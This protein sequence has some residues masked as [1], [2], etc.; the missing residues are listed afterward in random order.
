MN[1]LLM[2]GLLAG[3]CAMPGRADEAASASYGGGVR[4]VDL[5][6]KGSRGQFQ[7]YNGKL[8]S[9]AEGDVWVSNQGAK[10]LIDLDFNDIG[11]TEENGSLHVDLGDWFKGSAKI[12][13][14]THRQNMTDFGIIV[15]GTFVKIPMNLSRQKFPHDLN[16]LYKRTESEVNVALLD[17]HNSARWLSL[18]YWNVYKKGT[19]PSGYYTGGIL[20]FD[21]AN[22][23]NETN[24]VAL[25][26]GREITGS[27]AMALDLIRREFKDMAFVKKYGGVNTA[28]RPALPH[29]QV[30]AAEM[31]LRYNPSKDLAFTGALSGRQRENLF[32]LYK[33]NAAVAAFNAA[34]KASDKLSLTARLYGRMVEID[35]NK[36]YIN[37]VTNNPPANTHEFDKL[38]AR[39][40]FALSYRPI[41]PVLIKAGYKV[42]LTHRRDA[43]TEIFRAA[44]Y[45]D[46]TYVVNTQNA[47]SVA[48][49]DV[50]HIFSAGMKTELPCDISV[51]ADYKRM[52]ANR[53]A[54]VNMPTQGDEA[55][56][57][58]N[59]PLPGHIEFY[60]LAQY[61]NERN[62][63]EL[64][65][66]RLTRNAYRTGLDWDAQ[67]KVFVGADASYETSRRTTNGWFG[68]ANALTNPSLTGFEHVAGMY[69]RQNNT[70]TGIHACVN[71]PK[72]FVVKANGSYTWSTVATPLNM[73]RRPTPDSFWETSRPAT[74]VSRAPARPSSS[75]RP[76][77]RT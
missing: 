71:L 66:N 6:V 40:D 75:R 18:G 14:M 4:Y 59:V 57:A 12:D 34:Y 63:I 69:N 3:L 76:T 41:K 42:E 65:Q 44:V 19:A 49:D 67:D 30:T 1:T 7:E 43:P 2:A 51:D 39:G 72:G 77:A 21:E 74:C 52:E 58:V 36:D 28:V 37:V 55:N 5:D 45:S 8:Y 38:T 47:N 23:D 9:V 46:G 48:N 60:A 31:R 27:G 29:T 62:S 24:E 68:A 11:S 17:P 73:R 13:R 70:T 35:E 33:M 22:V 56:L 15:N 20:Y 26:V 61:L 64:T 25:G 53:A 10:G 32:N 50:K 16:M 54:F